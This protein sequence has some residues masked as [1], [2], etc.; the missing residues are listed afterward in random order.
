[1]HTWDR[2]R[3]STK[4]R[5]HFHRKSETLP[6]QTHCQ[7]LGTHRLQ[8]QASI[9]GE[10]IGSS[11]EHLGPVAS[12]SIKSLIILPFG[13]DFVIL[14]WL[15]PFVPHCFSFLWCWFFVAYCCNTIGIKDSFQS[16]LMWEG[17][18]ENSSQTTEQSL[19]LCLKT[20]IHVIHIT[21]IIK[22]WN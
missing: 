5:F 15:F 3:Q 19:Q 6:S 22:K 12:M 13:S 14:F 1:M 4:P 11:W 17:V 2:A 16:M 20:N 18:N 10:S 7:G 21:L 9:L 8:P